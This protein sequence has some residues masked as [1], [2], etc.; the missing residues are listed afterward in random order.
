MS[1]NRLNNLTKP[2]RILLS[3]YFI[4]LYLAFNS[5]QDKRNK[6]VLIERIYGRQRLLRKLQAMDIEKFDWLCDELKLKYT[7]VPEHNRN[8][9]RRAA[10]KAAARE[11]CWAIK[12]EKMEAFKKQLEQQREVFEEFKAK[13]LDEIEGMLK[14]LGITEMKSV[15]QVAKDLGLGEPYVK[16]KEKYKTRRQRLL[17]MKFELYKHLPK[18][19]PPTP[20]G[21]SEL[22]GEW[23]QNMGDSIEELIKSSLNYYHS[24]IPTLSVSYKI[25]T[26]DTTAR[27]WRFVTSKIDL[28]LGWA[29]LVALIGNRDMPLVYP[30]APRLLPACACSHQTCALNRYMQSRNLRIY[31]RHMPIQ[32]GRWNM[33]G[34][35]FVIV[36]YYSVRVAWRI[37]LWGNRTGL[38]NRLIL[39]INWY[40]A[41]HMYQYHYNVFIICHT[42]E[43]NV[44]QSA[45]SR[46][47]FMHGSV[48][49]NATL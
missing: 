32:I 6:V 10:R 23:R 44:C 25:P 16:K 28:L 40:I 1:H 37:G 46:Q 18:Y 48:S 31:R 47:Y 30:N 29:H 43:S 21:D 20:W 9:S 2:E 19:Q 38:C 8:L 49:V 34:P 3:L 5:F 22:G 15:E 27:L 4:L 36:V 39:C 13:E 24:G 42:G 11:K 45:P 7:P 26:I 17:E 12:A 41:T 35:T 33:P 14:N